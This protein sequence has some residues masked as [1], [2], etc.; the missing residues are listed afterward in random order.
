MSWDTIQ[1]DSTD[2]LVTDVLAEAQ[3]NLDALDPNEF[4][5]KYWLVREEEA[6]DFV[7]QYF[8][9][10]AESLFDDDSGYGTMLAESSKLRKAL[11]DNWLNKERIK[12]GG[13]AKTRRDR[14]GR[15]EVRAAV[16]VLKEFL[17]EFCKEYIELRPT[18]SKPEKY[19]FSKGQYENSS[20]IYFTKDVDGRNRLIQRAKIR[21]WFSEAHPILGLD[22]IMEELNPSRIW[23]S[24]G[25][26]YAR[27]NRILDGITIENVALS[28]DRKTYY[29]WDNVEIHGWSTKAPYS[30]FQGA[31]AYAQ[32]QFSDLID[33]K[34]VK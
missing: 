8:S 25:D 7:E 18:P 16:A 26:P 9:D 22:F 5:D 24:D 30:P 27:V 10:V 20:I 17:K 31:L 6:A 14:P 28:K 11:E 19:K 29:G 15:R 1:G 12:K 34:I 3:V 32:S 33:Y 13:T 21:E 23:R 2:D 4:D